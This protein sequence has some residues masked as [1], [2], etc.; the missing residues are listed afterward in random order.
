VRAPEILF[1][2]NIAAISATGPLWSGWPWILP[3]CASKSVLPPGRKL[4]ISRADAHADILNG[5]SAA[6]SS[7]TGSRS[8]Y[9]AHSRRRPRLRC[10][11]MRPGRGVHERADE[12]SFRTRIA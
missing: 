11:V 6:V 7:A 5:R 3:A 9:L 10:F 2:S 8:S 4:M 12:H 1:S